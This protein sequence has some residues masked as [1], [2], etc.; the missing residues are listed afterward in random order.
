MWKAPEFWVAVAFLVFFGLLAKMKVPG[1]ITKALDDRADAIRQELDQARRLR[2]EAQDLL[3]EYQQKRLQA[4][5]EA[6]AILEQARREADALKA[7]SDRSLKES[8]DRRSRLA[9]EKI[10]RAEAQALGE[11]R[12]AAV[13]AAVSAAEKVLRTR[14]QGDTGKTLVDEAIRDLK[15]RIN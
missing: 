14:A 13:E 4:E 2:E 15:T 5:N 8:L 7:E 12:A 1:M 3:T 9:E 6:K 11:V 10:A